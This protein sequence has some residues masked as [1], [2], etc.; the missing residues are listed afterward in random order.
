MF[1]HAHFGKPF[2]YQPPPDLLSLPPENEVCEGYVCTLV[3]QSICSQRGCLFLCMLGYTPP[4]QTLPLEQTAPWEHTP[5]GSRHPPIADTPITDTPHSRHPRG[6]DIHQS[7]HPPGTDTPGADTPP[8]ITCWEIWA[9]SGRYA[10]YWN[11]Y[12]FISKFR[13]IIYIEK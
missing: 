7:R 12:L 6:P 9:T 3:C 13:K 11:A 4:E 10:S 1:K 8:C 2:N 5:P